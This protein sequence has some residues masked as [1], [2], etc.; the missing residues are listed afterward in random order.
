MTA[1]AARRSSRA[2]STAAAIFGG[3]T[4][5]ICTYL[6]ETTHQPAMP[7]LWLSCAAAIGLAAALASG[8]KDAEETTAA[9]EQH[10]EYDHR[11]EAL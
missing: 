1:T 9:I 5:A 10:I 4:P 11:P 7:G 3:F 8:R 2:Y 6:I